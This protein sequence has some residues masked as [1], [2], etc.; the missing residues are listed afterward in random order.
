MLFYFPSILSIKKSMVYVSIDIETTGLNPNNNQII[1]I[2]AVIENTKTKLPLAELPTFHCIVTH[3]VY[4]G[5]AYPFFLNARIFKEIESPTGD[6]KIYKHYEVSKYFFEWL[7]SNGIMPNEEKMFSFTPAGKNF[8]SFDRLFLEKLPSFKERIKF[9]HRCL[10]PT[11]MFIDW[12]KDEELPNL[13]T[14]KERAGIKGEVT[15][16]AKEDAFD[17][18]EILRTVY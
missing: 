7:E 15:H 10:D 17:V 16:N 8:A 18:V 4:S 14:C 2:G 12:E 13:K 1:E 3:D 9:K 11:C 5:Q 6:I